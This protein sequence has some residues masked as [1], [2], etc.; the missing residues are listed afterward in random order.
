MTNVS[1]LR[2]NMVRANVLDQLVRT[3]TVHDQT[4]NDLHSIPIRIFG[5]RR[6]DLNFKFH[7]LH[8]LV[9]L[10]EPNQWII[11]LVLLVIR[12]QALP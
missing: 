6:W 10:L 3:S 8:V 4:K 9:C 1:A 7:V 5:S 11:V 2:A 12:V